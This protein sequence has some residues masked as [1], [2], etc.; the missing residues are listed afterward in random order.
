MST[1]KINTLQAVAGGATVPI[2]DVINGTARAWVNFNG[3]G[4]VAIRASYNVAG[5]TDNALGDWTVNFTNALADANFCA[6]PVPNYTE[7]TGVG[8]SAR[9]IQPKTYTA[10]SVRLIV[11]DGVAGVDCE[12]VNVT[13]HR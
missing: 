8:A 9:T 10:T 7:A 6:V 3:T 1:L 5:I 13:I 11:A 4:T 12:R 2:A